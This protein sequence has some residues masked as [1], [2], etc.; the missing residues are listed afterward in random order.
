MARRSSAFK[1]WEVCPAMAQEYSAKRWVFEQAS[2]PYGLE[3]YTDV[4]STKPHNI[5]ETHSCN[6]HCLLL[7]LWQTQYTTSPFLSLCLTIQLGFSEPFAQD[8]VSSLFGVWSPQS[9][10]NGF[11]GPQTPKW[12]NQPG[13]RFWKVLIFGA[14]DPG[15]Y[16]I[17]TL[18]LFNIAMENDP[19]IDG[20][21]GFT[22][23]R[24]WFS[25]A[26]LNNQRVYIYT[27]TWYDRSLLWVV[28][29]ERFQWNERPS[30]AHVTSKVD[31]CCV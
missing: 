21:P 28:K 16:I 25:M 5:F 10:L 22:Y 27:Y 31:Q 18:W 19:F 1:T 11:R 6:D 17:Y 14:K 12:T 23:S 24:W 8:A 4:P 26:T 13:L 2:S 30:C 9:L 7:L 15:L 20:L 3:N 29:V